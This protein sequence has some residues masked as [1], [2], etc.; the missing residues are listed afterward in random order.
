MTC[1]VVACLTVLATALQKRLRVY[2]RTGDKGKSSLYTGERRLKTDVTFAAL[3]DTDE[4]NAAIGIAREHLHGVDA[5]LSAQLVHIQS[6]L[7]DIG[8]AV[9]TPVSSASPEAAARAR[10]PSEEVVQLER[11]IDAMDEELPLLRS[12][13]LPVRSLMHVTCTT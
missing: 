6:R 2:T 9:A 10:F 3:G 4:L 5:E 8:S 12:F 13:I 11:W 7:L 1:V